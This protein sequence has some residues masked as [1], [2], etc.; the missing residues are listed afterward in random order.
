[1]AEPSQSSF[2]SVIPDGSGYN[3][4]FRHKWRVLGKYALGST[5]IPEIHKIVEDRGWGWHFIPHKNMDYRKDNWYE[6]QT[7]VLSFENKDDM[8][9]AILQLDAKS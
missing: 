2:I 6:D 5:W 3:C 7:L 1:M 8:I 9:Q 4:I